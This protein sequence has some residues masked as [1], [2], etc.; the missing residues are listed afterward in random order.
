MYDSRLIKIFKIFFF[1]G[2]NTFGE[3]Y[4]L[5]KTQKVKNVIR[6]FKMN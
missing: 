2:G 4:N 5:E 1:R 3:R 6:I